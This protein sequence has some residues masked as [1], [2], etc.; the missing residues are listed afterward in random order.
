MIAGTE[1]EKNQQKWVDGVCAG[2]VPITEHTLDAL[3]RRRT[4]LTKL[5]ANERERLEKRAVD[6]TDFLDHAAMGL[7]TQLV[8]IGNRVAELAGA[9]LAVNAAEEFV[10]SFLD[11]IPPTELAS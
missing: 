4:H 11:S 5:L 6:V 9:L 3:R 8:T 2:K 1:F 10:A 7:S